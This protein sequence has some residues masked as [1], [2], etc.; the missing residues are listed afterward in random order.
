[1]K[2]KHKHHDELD[3][4]AEETSARRQLAPPSADMN[5][6]PLID[7]LLVLLIIFMAT[8]PMTQKGQDINLPPDSTQP[9]KPVDNTQIVVEVSPD[10]KLTLNRQNIA[11]DDL[12][13]R[14]REL[15]ENRSEKTMFISAAGT[16]PYGEVMPVIDT[17]IGAGGR[18]AIVTDGMRKR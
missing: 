14:L 13:A 16:I 3:D 2:H 6:T 11:F 10:R 1:M 7:V 9:Q 17:A 8:L 12:Q 18:V 15:L 4:E 5:V